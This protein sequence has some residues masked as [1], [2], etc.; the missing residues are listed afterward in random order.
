[1]YYYYL[2]SVISSAHTKLWTLVVS[3]TC[4][5]CDN[6]L[7]GF[8]LLF[9]FVRPQLGQRNEALLRDWCLRFDI[10]PDGRRIVQGVQEPSGH[11]R[12]RVGKVE[13]ASLGP[14]NMTRVIMWV[15][16][17]TDSKLCGNK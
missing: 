3:H 12:A 5:L 2:G 13:R 15:N 7:V 17:H 10:C 14:G 1:M 11:K 4:L 8:Y 9:R 16:M 6:G